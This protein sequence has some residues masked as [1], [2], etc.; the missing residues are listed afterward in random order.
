MS[1]LLTVELTAL[2]LLFLETCNKFLHG[3]GWLQL[4]I[5]LAAIAA[6][7][8]THG[9]RMCYINSTHA[10]WHDGI[11][12]HGKFISLRNRLYNH[13]FLTQHTHALAH[14]PKFVVVTIPQKMGTNTLFPS[15]RAIWHLPIY[16]DPWHIILD[17]LLVRQSHFNICTENGKRL[18]M[19]QWEL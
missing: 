2:L 16:I 1:T 4:D 6:R 15:I 17:I 9:T 7:W 5:L 18:F 12:T 14:T 10:L 13:F 19:L 3:S 11:Q 8:H